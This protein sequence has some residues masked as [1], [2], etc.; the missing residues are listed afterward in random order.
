MSFAALSWF[1]IVSRSPRRC[2]ALPPTAT[3]IR[4]LDDAENRRAA[5]NACSVGRIVDVK[6]I[7]SRE[8]GIQGC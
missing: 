2:S 1:S 5:V 8:G 6:V 4:W 7:A 3:T